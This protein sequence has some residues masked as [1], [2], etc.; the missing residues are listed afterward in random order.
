MGELKLSIKMALLCVVFISAC[1]VAQQQEGE[2]KIACQA[3]DYSYLVG[4]FYEDV[5]SKLPQHRWKRP[6]FM[7]TDDYISDRLNVETD[8]SGIIVAVKCG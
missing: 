7:Y 3:S 2:A 6:D 8:E 1:S 5:K 4:K